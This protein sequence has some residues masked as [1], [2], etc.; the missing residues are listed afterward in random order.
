MGRWE[1]RHLGAPLQR[2]WPLTAGVPTLLQPASAE[3]LAAAF[4]DF[5][6]GALRPL[7]SG[8]DGLASLRPA[9]CFTVARLTGPAS[10]D[11]PSATL[12]LPASATWAEA[13]SLAAAYGLTLSDIPDA[14]GDATIGGTLARAAWQPSLH[15]AATARARC[16]GLTA[17]LPDGA[18]YAYKTASRTASGPDL[19]THFFGAEGGSG[20]I[21]RATLEA[22][23]EAKP[24]AFVALPLTADNLAAVIGLSSRFA[25]AIRLLPSPEPGTMR[26]RL[27]ADRPES[28]LILDALSALGA[29]PCQ[30]PANERPTATRWTTLPHREAALLLDGGRTFACLV[31]GPTHLTIAHDETLDLACD[32]PELVRS[33]PLGAGFQQG[34]EAQS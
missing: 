12:D 11:E 33:G 29:H 1:P 34:K 10:V 13:E 19:R 14:F 7:G 30:N 22:S 28:S 21:L 5:P 31:L 8:T 24:P 27:R 32:H 3:A 16:I 20:A 9:A 2:P 6:A 17:L 4:R 15:P 26:L 25:R 23:R 18:I